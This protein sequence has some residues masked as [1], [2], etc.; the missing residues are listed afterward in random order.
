M[1]ENMSELTQTKSSSG[2]CKPS[3]VRTAKVNDSSM[4]KMLSVQWHKAMQIALENA[5][6]LAAWKTLVTC[7]L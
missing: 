1:P 6:G 3:V 7:C 5:F 2:V 4:K